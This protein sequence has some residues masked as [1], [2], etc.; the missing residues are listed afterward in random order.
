MGKCNCATICNYRSKT[1]GRVI[2]I[3]KATLQVHLLEKLHELGLGLMCVSSPHAVVLNIRS[4]DLAASS[5]VIVRSL[6]VM[7][8]LHELDSNKHA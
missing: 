2:F 5:S 8:T 3:S 4:D 6:S 1:V 7:Y